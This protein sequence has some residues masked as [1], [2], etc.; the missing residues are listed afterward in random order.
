MSTLDFSERPHAAG[1]RKRDAFW[2]NVQM[3]NWRALCAP[4]FYGRDGLAKLM[5]VLMGRCRLTWPSSRTTSALI[6][7]GPRQITEITLA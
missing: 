1:A 2:L 3:P 5:H 7:I 6:Y 4:D